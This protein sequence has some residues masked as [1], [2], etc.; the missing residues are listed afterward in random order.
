[1]LPPNVSLD[2]A[3]R[4]LRQLTGRRQRLRQENI[5]T[6]EVN[7]VGGEADVEPDSEPENPPVEPPVSNNEVNTIANP[8]PIEEAQTDQPDDPLDSPS[9]KKRKR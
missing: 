3:M 5:E 1:M 4:E 8:A 6:D 9:K 7:T 2:D